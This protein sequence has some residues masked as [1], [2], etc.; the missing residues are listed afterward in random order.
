MTLSWLWR[1][2]IDMD[3][4]RRKIIREELRA[5]DCAVLEEHL[6]LPIALHRNRQAVTVPAISRVTVPATPNWDIC[7]NWDKRD[8]RDRR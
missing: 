1:K 2:L 3:R 5:F 4:E 7:D 6:R 8:E